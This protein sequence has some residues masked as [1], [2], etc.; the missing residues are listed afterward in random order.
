MRPFLVGA[1]LA[2]AVRTDDD[3]DDDDVLLDA[4]AAALAPRDWHRPRPRRAAAAA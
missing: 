2:L 1:P 4:A 3:D